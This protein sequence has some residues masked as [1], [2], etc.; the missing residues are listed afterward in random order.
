MYAAGDMESSKYQAAA[1]QDATSHA[2][3]LPGACRTAAS[4]ATLPPDLALLHSA[5]C[6]LLAARGAE[7][8][9][10]AAGGSLRHEL[11]SMARTHEAEQ[12]AA[13][14]GEGA[15]VRGLGA[16][17]MAFASEEMDAA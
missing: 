10:E 6:W 14:Q 1:P 15:F 2:A 11:E 9:A 3:S 7:M 8:E 4:P 12:G 16:Q 5:G 17:E 13:A